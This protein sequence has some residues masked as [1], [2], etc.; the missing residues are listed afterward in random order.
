[1]ILTINIQNFFHDSGAYFT[2]VWYCERISLILIFARVKGTS[3]VTITIEPVFNRLSLTVQNNHFYS[4]FSSD[5]HKFFFRASKM[6]S[7]SRSRSCSTPI[8]ATT[9]GTADAKCSEHFSPQGR[10]I[11]RG[12]LKIKTIKI[13]MSFH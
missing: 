6:F 9:T 7:T 10:Q 12:G 4:R 3:W 1:M 2:F 11:K 5:S 8:R 13:L